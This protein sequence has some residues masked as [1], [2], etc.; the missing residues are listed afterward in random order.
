MNSKVKK[1]ILLLL[2]FV[3]VFGVV[4]IS[5]RP[6]QAPTKQLSFNKSQYSIDDP[7][8]IWVVVNKIRPLNP[9][10]FVSADLVI[11]NVTL[12]EPGDDSMK[13]RPAAA[14]ALEN[15]FNAAKKENVNLMLASAY[16]SYANQE[17]IYKSEVKGFGQEIADTQSARPGHSEHQ[18]G[19]GAD[20]AP[21]NGKCIIEDCFADTNE[22]KWVA[23]NA[24][25]YGFIVR[26]IT[27]KEHITGFRPEPWHL[28]F[29]GIDLSMEMNR[30][31]IKTLEEFFGLPPA[32]NYL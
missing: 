1:L 24:Y 26:Y 28:R 20:V 5:N 14:T 9:K 3:L 4:W 11:P 23:A 22:G 21:A 13:L 18:A 10:D 29:V 2:F 8:S 19:L 30:Q 31:N 12:K 17:A 27:S 16:R 7:G 6:S 25:K 15:L 32:P